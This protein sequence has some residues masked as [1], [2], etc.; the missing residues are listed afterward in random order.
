MCSKMYIVQNRDLKIGIAFILV[1]FMFI[2]VCQILHIRYYYERKWTPI[3]IMRRLAASNTPPFCI[4]VFCL[5]FAHFESVFQC[6]CFK[7]N[8]GTTNNRCV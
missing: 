3:G 2:Y 5:C 4:A 6:L 8:K 1:T 7:M